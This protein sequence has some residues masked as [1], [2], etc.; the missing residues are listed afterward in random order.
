MGMSSRQISEGKLNLRKIFQEIITNHPSLKDRF[1]NAKPL[2]SVKGFGLPLGGKYNEISGERFLLIGDAA[3]L[4]DPLTGEGIGNA[5]RSGRVAAEHIT[6]CL[7]KGDFSATMNKAYDKEI[8][9]RMMTEFK[10]DTFIRS[11]IQHFPVS[12]DIFTGIVAST[13]GM[14]ASFLNFGMW[15]HKAIS[16]I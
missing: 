14:S 5:L 8:Y 15:L 12:V 13:K 16:K 9:K 6:Q 11:I 7:E 2:E 10:T 3:S 4:I 1:L